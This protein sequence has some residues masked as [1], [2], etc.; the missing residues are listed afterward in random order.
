MGH[1]FGE[2]GWALGN[3]ILYWIYSVGFYY[4]FSYSYIW[5]EHHILVEFEG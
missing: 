4:S 2:V 1:F 5:G 3:F